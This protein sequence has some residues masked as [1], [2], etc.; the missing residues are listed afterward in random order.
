MW[1]DPGGGCFLTVR[2]AEDT[3]WRLEPVSLS[4]VP[5]LSARTPRG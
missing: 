5:V 2:A 1:V 4:A 3:K